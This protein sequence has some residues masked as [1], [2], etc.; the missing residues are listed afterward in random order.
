MVRRIALRRIGGSV[1]VTIPKDLAERY[2]M[3]VG[4]D[5]FAV[6]TDRGLLLTAYDPT[7]ERAMQVYERGAKRYRHALRE[8]AK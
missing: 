3:A 8:L 4:E 5:G 6:E 1:G 7:F 2:H